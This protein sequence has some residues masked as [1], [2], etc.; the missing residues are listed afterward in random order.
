MNTLA[1]SA[2]PKD[3]HDNRTQNAMIPFNRFG[4][5][6]MV[7]LTRRIC[8]RDDC[9]D[10]ALPF[11]G[12][13]GFN[14]WYL[15]R[16]LKPGIDPLGPENRLLFSA[17]LLTGSA[18]PCSARLHVN[19]LSP[20]TGILGSANIG[21][22]VGAW[23]R[24]CNL[25]S[26]V[27]RGA[28]PEPVYLY[29]DETSARLMPAEDLWGLD[30]FAV[31]DRLRQIHA[32]EKVRILTIGPGGENQ[33]R[34]AAIM[35][36][37]D[38]AAGR[39]GLGAVMGAK[40]LKAVVIAKGSHKHLPADTPPKKQAVKTYVNLVKTAPEFSFFSKYG[41]AGYLSWVNEFGIMGAK[42]YTEIGVP[43]I[44][45]IDGRNLAKQ[46]VR[47]SGCA[48]CPVQC[49]A[50]LVMDPA[51]PEE[52]STR[53]EF[54]PVINF[55]PKCGLSDMAAIIRLDN[56]CN[57]LGVDTT[58]TASVIAFAMDL[59][60]KGLMPDT[61]KQDLD[62]SW[63]HAQ[64]M[65]ILIHRIVDGTTPLGRM[66]SKGVRQA[67]KQ[68]GGKAA[69]HAAHVRGLE[70]TAYHPNAIMGTALGYAVSSRGGDYNN[71]YASLEYSWSKEQA[72]KE[73][74][75]ALAVD[76][77]ATKAKGRLIRKAVVTN[78]LV[79]TIGLCK[80]PVLSLLKSFNLEPEI[81]LV[82]TLADTHVSLK[83]LTDTGL[84]IAAMERRFNLR[85]TE[86][87]ISDNL[88]DMFFSRN[89]NPSG[90]TRTSFTAMLAEF[91]QA[92]GW[93]ENGVPPDPDAMKK[94]EPMM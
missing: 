36:E 78:I 12:G 18:A 93:D 13:R 55:G 72:I 28:S 27:I 65:E 57:R 38:H 16:H 71:V 85:H 48:K 7:D 47:S 31:Q 64:T 89:D 19:A 40:H 1:G 33:V 83:Q 82:N 92:M 46:I 60:E 6:L 53:P 44:S 77:H 88:P 21:G 56:L 94:T 84:A 41:G 75:T 70:L 42:N 25:A 17:G 52:M 26:I 67:A 66:L 68:I 69:A 15:Y 76:I 58:S 22:Y 32:P 87:P 90:L 8:R 61:L 45:S 35:T 10:D 54:E 49:K 51:K 14:A 9:P 5:L 91:Y 24:S 4:K 11:L 62:L 23:L 59:N 20:L 29:V 73:F 43:D 63:G 74:G 30:V 80:V 81:V 50:D 37:K 34:F 39:T 79:D 2:L 3:T 86:T